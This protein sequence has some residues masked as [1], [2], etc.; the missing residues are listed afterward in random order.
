MSPESETNIFLGPPS[1]SKLAKEPSCE[2]EL[3]IKF[4][5]TS[6]RDVPDCMVFSINEAT[7]LKVLKLKLR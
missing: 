4:M 1:S 6:S 3:E 2:G 7:L 5:E